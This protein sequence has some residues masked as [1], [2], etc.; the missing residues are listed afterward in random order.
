MLSFRKCFV[1]KKKML[2]WNGVWPEGLLRRDEVENNVKKGLNAT[3][4][5]ISINQT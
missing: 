4:E 1:I 3:Q 2:P 5:G